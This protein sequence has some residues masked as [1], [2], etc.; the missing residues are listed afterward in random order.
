MPLYRDSDASWTWQYVDGNGDASDVSSRDF[1]MEFYQ[2][3]TTVSLTMGDGIEFST[4]GTDGLVDYTLSLARINQFCPG[5][6]RIRQWD[7][8]GSTSIL[9]HEGSDTIE[10]QGYDA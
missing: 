7:D 8:A 4:D 3:G 9:T 1:R 6:V 10:G 2:N 5:Q